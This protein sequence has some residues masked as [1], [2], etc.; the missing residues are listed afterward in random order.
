MRTIQ[1]ALLAIG[2][3]LLVVYFGIRLHGELS[4]RLSLLAF[5]SAHTKSDKQITPKQIVPGVDFNLWSEKRIA[6][7]NQSL[8]QHFSPPRAVL[9]ISKIHLE[10]PVF[11]GTDDLTLNRG[12]GRIIGTA[13]LDTDKNGNIGIA[14][15]RDGF[16]RGLKDVQNGDTID[17]VLADKTMSFVIDKIQIVDPSNVSVLESGSVSSLTLVTCYPFYFNGSAPQRYIV[18]ASLILPAPSEGAT[19]TQNISA[20]RRRQQEKTE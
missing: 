19:T 1:R 9:H 5:H 15:H 16:F 7:F 20:S 17:L 6:A 2:L 12:V 14:G 10:V 8:T 3:T 18:H 11:E 4:S 13:H